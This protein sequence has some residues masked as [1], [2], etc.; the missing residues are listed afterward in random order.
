VLFIVGSTKSRKPSDLLDKELRAVMLRLMTQLL[1]GYRSCLTMV[2]IHPQP[3]ITFHKAAFLGL[4]NLGP[5]SPFM[6][7][8][9]DCMFFNEF[10]MSRGPPW[11]RCDI[12]DELYA[13]MG[14]QL[15]AEMADPRKV[16]AHIEALAR[17]LYDNE[18]SPLGVSASPGG[19]Q[20]WGQRIPLPT[21]GH[22]MRVHQPAF[23]LLDGALVQEVI[24]QGQARRAQNAPY[25][26]R[27]SASGGASN[28][29]QFKLVPMGQRQEGGSGGAGS[30]L[31][32]SAR[33]LEVL[34]SCISSIFEN[35]ISDA[36]KSFPAV[37]R[38]LKSKVGNLALC[39]A[40]NNLRTDERRKI[41]IKTLVFVVF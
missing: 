37:I 22:M 29:S 7:R 13:V 19:G 11:R 41:K 5:D 38:T 34:R 35:K 17:E 36:K 9:L 12:F 30:H 20:A 3:Y 2:R 39:G 26:D 8:F 27:S 6:T 23:P 31:T 10:I 24:S 21:E 4:R 32:N 14:E 1:Q 18:N 33:R 28:S 15:A 16:L 40:F 25:S